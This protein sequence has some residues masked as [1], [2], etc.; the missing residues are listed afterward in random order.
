M[1]EAEIAQAFLTTLSP[2]N[3]LRKQ[4]EAFLISTKGQ[5]GL[6]E[7]LM[8][9]ANTHENFAVRQSAVVYLKNQCKAWVPKKKQIPIP[10]VDKE[11]MKSHIF[12]CIYHNKEEKIR[13]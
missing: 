7:T 8:K 9:L 13:S 3:D 1:S 10:E 5:P 11:S 12:N 4:A 6:F 2:N